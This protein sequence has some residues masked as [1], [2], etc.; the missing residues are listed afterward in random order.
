M[1]IFRAGQTRP[2]WLVRLFDLQRDLALAQADAAHR[3]LRALGANRALLRRGLERVTPTL[4]RGRAFEALVVDAAR[5]SPEAAIGFARA[6]DEWN[7]QAHLGQLDLPVLILWGAKD[8]IVPRAGL[9]R[10]VRGLRHGRLVV[11]PDVGH[12]PQLEQ[13]ERFARLLF[14]FTALRP[15]PPVPPG[16]LRRLW[17]RLPWAAR[18][19]A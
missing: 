6:L 1:P 7:V 10:T 15:I 16:W 5:M 17:D 2:S 12:A 19:T 14:D 3:V 9:E 8:I 18:R 13:P 11:W 4:R